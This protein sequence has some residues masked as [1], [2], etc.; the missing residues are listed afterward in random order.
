MNKQIFLYDLEKVEG[1]VYWAKGINYQP[2]N[3]P[4]TTEGVFI[5]K[6][7]F[8]ILDE[9][10]ILTNDAK[11]YYNQATNKAYYEYFERTKTEEELLKDEIKELKLQQ[12]TTGKITADLAYELMML[13]G[14]K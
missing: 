8:P 1:E 10:N 7:E 4:P 13:K 14:A 5:N 6:E 2:H 9:V 11:L 3:N 12:E